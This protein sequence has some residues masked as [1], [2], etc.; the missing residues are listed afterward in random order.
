[1][2]VGTAQLNITPEP[3]IDLAGFAI[4]PQPSLDVLDPLWL[5]ALYLE[6][7][8]ERLL[9][10]HAD[11]LAL[12]QP[13]ADRW[14]GWV[15]SNLGIP[16]TRVVFSTTHTHSGPAT[17]QLT[18]CG[19]VRSEYIAW[20]DGHVQR[21][22]RAAVRGTEPC[23][24]R[25]VQGSCRLGVD[26]REGNSGHT[27]SRVVAFGWQRRDGT[28]KAAFLNYA[29]H[30]VCLRSNLISAD[31][32][33]EAARLVSE[34]LPGRPVTLVCSGACGNINPPGV[35]VAPAQ[36][37]EWARQIAASVWPKLLVSDQNALSAGGGTL[38][39]RSAQVDLPLETWGVDEIAR[40]AAACLAD[41]AGTHEFSHK[42]GEAVEVWR[43]TMND[44]LRRG[45]P[46]S[47]HAELMAIQ[48]GRMAMVTVNAEVFSRFNELAGCGVAEPVVAIG[49]ANGMI[50]YLPT[51]EAY[52]K[53]SYEVLWSMLFYNL[54]RAQQGGLELLARH[55]QNLIAN[56]PRPT[57][58]VAFPEK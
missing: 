2:N 22:A 31:W 33:G 18:G 53:G 28:F 40:Y 35:G 41:P 8:P 1:M 50:G 10:L 34:S 36:M 52:V 49:C 48:L 17:I 27:D 7:G 24:L 39:V 23:R 30:P 11:L 38:R 45:E 47:T 44:R 25:A 58:P 57:A 5:R 46:A 19:E 13:L 20:L 37:G 29:M 55:A 4:R 16:R 9:W 43:A 12:D 14:R 3:G 6:A 26:R 42:F 21:A 54:P 15:E 51:A 32:P 56:L